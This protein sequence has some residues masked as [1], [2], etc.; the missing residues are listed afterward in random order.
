M[1][2]AHAALAAAAD[3]PTSAPA[4]VP[5]G[6]LYSVKG[7]TCDHC[8]DAVT[9][10]VEQVQGVDHIAVDVEAGRV[11]VIGNGFSDEAIRHAVDEAGYELVA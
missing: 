4:D 10:E 5:G 6:R 2:E 8:V 11:A 3:Q 9:E 1:C 7:M